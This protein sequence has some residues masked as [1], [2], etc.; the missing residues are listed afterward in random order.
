MDFFYRFCC[1]VVYVGIGWGVVSLVFRLIVLGVFGGWFGF[2]FC[3][4]WFFGWGYGCF[5]VCGRVVVVVV[6]CVCFGV[7]WGGWGLCYCLFGS[8]LGVGGF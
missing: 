1:V 2:W 8:I 3:G 4:G 6:G 5:G 7:V